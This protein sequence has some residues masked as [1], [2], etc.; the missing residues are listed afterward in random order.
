MRARSTASARWRRPRG[1][2]VH[3]LL[4]AVDGFCEV[5]MP[6]RVSRG[7]AAVDGVGWRARGRG[8]REGGRGEGTCGG[9]RDGGRRRRGGTCRFGASR[10]GDSGAGLVDLGR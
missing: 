3:E 2:S 8:G 4:H 9:G 6:V 10:F 1:G 5:R 7:H